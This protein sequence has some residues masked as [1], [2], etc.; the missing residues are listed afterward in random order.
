MTNQYFAKVVNMKPVS[1]V[2]ATDEA[3]A[4]TLRKENYEPCSRAFY[5][6][7]LRNGTQRPSASAE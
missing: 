7:A 4:E 5:E 6:A 1:V 2:K 3:H